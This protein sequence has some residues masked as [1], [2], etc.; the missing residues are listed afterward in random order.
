MIKLNP[1]IKQE[2]KN[3]V[4]NEIG[5]LEDDLNYALTEIIDN[6]KIKELKDPVKREEALTLAR[7][8]F[9]KG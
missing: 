3:A 6:L 7:E 4:E 8:I 1:K 9:F 5:S 2:V